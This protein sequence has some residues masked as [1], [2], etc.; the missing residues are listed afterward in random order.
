[1]KVIFKSKVVFLLI[2]SFFIHSKNV[3]SQVVVTAGYTK[4]SY[5]STSLTLKHSQFFLYN[6]KKYTS[7]DH[8]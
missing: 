3:H 7:T 1:M 5:F 8:V 4:V 2:F 6:Y